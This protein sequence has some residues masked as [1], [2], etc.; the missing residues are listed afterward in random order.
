MLEIKSPHSNIGNCGIESDIF[1]ITKKI[2]S[3]SVTVTPQ[4]YLLMQ[5][6]SKFTQKSYLVDILAY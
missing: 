2:T 5:L 1:A 4:S 3:V 6:S